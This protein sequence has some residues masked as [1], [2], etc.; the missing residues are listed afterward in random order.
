[1]SW[2]A[3]IQ[4]L[5]T[6]TPADWPALADALEVPEGGRARLLDGAWRLDVDRSRDFYDDEGFEGFEDELAAI[7]ERLEALVAELEP[8][9]GRASNL[10]AELRCED[11]DDPTSYAEACY[12][13]GALA[14]RCWQR[15]GVRVA[16]LLFHPDRELPLMAEARVESIA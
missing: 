8:A 3:L 1:M 11:I 13:E 2:P 10:D 6:T 15:E 4:Q 9:L 14:L 16:L 5:A 12:L 7:R